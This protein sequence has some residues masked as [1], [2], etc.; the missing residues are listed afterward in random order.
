MRLEIRREA[1]ADIDAIRQ[2]NRLAFGREEEAQLVDALRTA[3]QVRVS[4]VAIADGE[5]VGHILLSAIEIV[6]PRRAIPALAL[7]PMAVLPERQN[8]GIGSVL[9][10][11]ALEACREQGHRIVV[12]VGHPAFYPRFGV[13]AELAQPLHSAFSGPAWMA[14]ELQPGALAD[15]AGTVRY[16][17]E[18]EAF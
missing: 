6:G 13:S 10:R 5:L 18:W 3:A 2:V 15:V 11:D 17:T 4:L 12:V 9:V 16:P 8:L 1:P 7:G 14:L